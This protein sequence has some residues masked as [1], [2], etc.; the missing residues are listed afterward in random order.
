MLI[1]FVVVGGKPGIPRRAVLYNHSKCPTSG[2]LVGRP[3]AGNLCLLQGSCPAAIG[4]P[5]F[6]S[7]SNL[8]I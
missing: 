3:R 6:S 8:F 2:N 7:S 1:V 4:E 5:Y